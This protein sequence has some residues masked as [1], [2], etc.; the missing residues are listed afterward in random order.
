MGNQIVFFFAKM[1]EPR[2]QGVWQALLCSQHRGIPSL[3][4]VG[5]LPSDPLLLG[6]CS[7]PRD[8]SWPTGCE[9]AV[10]RLGPGGPETLCG[11]L[12]SLL[13][14]VE[15]TGGASADGDG[16]LRAAQSRRALRAR[17]KR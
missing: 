8:W 6:V 14:S 10:L 12:V 11:A 7:G 3:V 17:N 5:G 2:G 9:G 15:E 16:V 4:G 1:Q 13:L